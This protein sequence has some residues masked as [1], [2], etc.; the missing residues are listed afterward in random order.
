MSF[1]KWS[2]AQDAPS[3]DSPDDKSKDAP[4]VGQPPAQPEK[5][6]AEVAPAPKS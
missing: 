1:K 3:K 4:A 2:S 5:T 6:P